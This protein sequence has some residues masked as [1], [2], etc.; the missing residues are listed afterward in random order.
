MHL[1]TQIE[2]CHHNR[3]ETL[4]SSWSPVLCLEGSQQ[5]GASKS[6][7]PFVLSLGCASLPIFFLLFYGAVF[8][9]SY[10]LSRQKKMF[11]WSLCYAWNVDSACSWQAVLRCHGLRRGFVPCWH[12]ALDGHGRSTDTALGVVVFRAEEAM[13]ADAPPTT[14]VE[15]SVV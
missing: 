7:S 15:C 4:C 8:H 6:G 11:L 10:P 3:I 1:A 12:Q 14:V 2:F 13:L 9:S 5:W